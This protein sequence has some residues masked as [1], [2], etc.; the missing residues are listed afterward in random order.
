M[1]GGWHLDLQRGAINYCTI[2]DN[3]FTDCNNLTRVTIKYATKFTDKAFGGNFREVYEAPAVIDGISGGLDMAKLGGI[4]TREIGSN[5]WKME[6]ALG[7]K[8]LN[9]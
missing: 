4:F 8:V 6:K 2:G 3:A 1:D 7:E 5:T 9:K